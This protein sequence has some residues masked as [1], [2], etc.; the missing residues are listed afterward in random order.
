MNGVTRFDRR[1]EG[2]KVRV[3]G[4]LQLRVGGG[5]RKRVDVPCL[6]IEFIEFIVYSATVIRSLMFYIIYNPLFP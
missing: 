2:V 3:W 4:G 5:R 6:F 1:G